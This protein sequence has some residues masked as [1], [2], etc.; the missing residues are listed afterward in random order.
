VR[1][2][3]PMSLFPMFLKLDG[4]RCLVVGSGTVARPKIES[5]L[6]AGAQVAVVA[7]D[8]QPEVA[9]WAREGKL[10]WRQRQFVEGDLAGAFL[11][12]AATNRKAVN[13]AVAE[14]ARAQGVLCN[15]VDDPP[16]CDF[17]Y[18]SVVERGDL[19]IAV[20]TA[21]KS[22]ALAQRLREELSALLPEDV[23]PWLDSLG[24]Q[25]LRVLA[26]LP[27]SEERREILHQLARREFCDPRD[28]PVERKLEQIL[29]RS[30]QQAGEADSA[31]VGT[32]YLTGA[33]PGSPEL[34]TVRARTL[35]QT[36]S[37]ILYD[38]L[39]PPAVVALARPDALAV[40]VGKR[41]GQKLV[42]QEQIH[43]W[44]IEYASEGHSVVRLKGG[45][46]GL[47]GRG[48]E[49]IAA[50][51]RAGIQFEIVPGVSAP[52]AAAAAAKVSLTDRER[53]SRVVFTTRHLAGNE[54]GGVSAPDAASTLA[55]Y[56]PG[57]DYAAL[58]TE[59][60]AKGWPAE[61]TCVLVSAASLSSQQIVTV[62]IGELGTVSP[63]P[64]PAVILILPQPAGSVVRS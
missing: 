39:V 34:L 10:E 27:A 8:A 29:E 41:C 24:E 64:A 28:C 45:D 31:H 36:A 61:T 48:A 47:F 60:L 9:A 11:V 20:S 53:S 37:C 13:H 3:L 59:L 15:S 54:T 18:P 40:N 14:A 6:R 35:I 52:L 25:R 51:T 12:V 16:D 50:L 7:P 19:Q 57:K 49:E 46:P 56:M 1:R 33:G 21:G 32:V 55:L 4:R 2:E 26:A 43:A 23:G 22:P 42:T 62:S 44:M 17:Y 5:L 30:A 58:Q 38:D 63:L